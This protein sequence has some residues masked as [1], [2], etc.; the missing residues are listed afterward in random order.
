MSELALIRSLGLEAR[1]YRNNYNSSNLKVRFLIEF[2]ISD[3][4][5]QY[6]RSTK[7]VLTDT[8]ADNRCNYSSVNQ[9]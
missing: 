9:V 5:L 2:E 8:V 6:M 3:D 4:I 1:M 7:K